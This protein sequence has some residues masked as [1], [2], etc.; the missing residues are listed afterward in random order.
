MD[1]EFTTLRVSTAAFEG[2]GGIDAF[3]EIWG[4]KI[5]RMEM[6]ALDDN[7]LEVNLVLRCLTNCAI[8]SGSLSPMRNSITKELIADDD[9][10]LVIVESGVAECSQHGRIV[11][12]DAGEAV[13]TANGAPGTFTGL[14]ATRVVNFRFSRALLDHHVGDLD[15]RVARPIPKNDR[16]LQLLKTY[17]KTLT[18]IRDLGTADLRRTVGMHLHD[19]AALSLGSRHQHELS[20]RAARLQAVKMDIVT[21]VAD[22]H[23]TVSDVAARHRVTPRYVQMLFESEGRTF[24][25][26]VL[27]QRLNVAYRMLSA[28]RYAG[29]TIASIAF[30]AGFSNLSYFNRTFRR[31]YDVTPSDVRHAARREE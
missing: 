26:Y 7:P 4:R 9:L 17:S 16:A 12:L 28:P 15:N 25:D 14:T 21:R 1:S 31:R 29:W 22:E 5:L 18:E 13:L 20:L 19:L 11:R 24:T 6:N 8:A 27:E 3:L 23:L 10:V 2:N 30:E